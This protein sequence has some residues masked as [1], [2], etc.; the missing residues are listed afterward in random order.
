MGI[1]FGETSHI[2][3]SDLALKLQNEPQKFKLLPSGRLAVTL[4]Q[5]KDCTEEELLRILKDHIGSYKCTLRT[6]KA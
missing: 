3:R 2:D 5:D 6:N 4:Q 1:T